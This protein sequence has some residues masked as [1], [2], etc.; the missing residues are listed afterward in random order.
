MEWMAQGGY[1]ISVVF[2]VKAV[3]HLPEARCQCGS[4]YM[5]LLLD[6]PSPIV[7]VGDITADRQ[8]VPRRCA[9][10][11]T[12]QSVPNRKVVYKSPSVRDGALLDGA[13]HGLRL[14]DG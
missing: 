2:N 11:S 13:V 10:T 1:Q 9:Q 4:V 3:Q 12:W 8:P 5:N 6:H 14:L 7:P